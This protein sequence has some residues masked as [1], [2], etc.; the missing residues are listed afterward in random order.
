MNVIDPGHEYQVNSIGDE[1]DQII[2]FLKRVNGEL[3]HDG[4]TNEEIIKVLIDRM[5]YLQNQVPCVENEIAITG[6]TIA[7]NSLESRTTKR[8]AQGIMSKDI[9]HV[10]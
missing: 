6:L 1:P 4:T 9:S 7:L 3:I 2:S 5:N 10:S 8:V